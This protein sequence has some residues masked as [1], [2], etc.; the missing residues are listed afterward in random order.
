[1]HTCVHCT[2]YG[3]W[4]TVY[5]RHHKHECERNR[6]PNYMRNA[7]IDISINP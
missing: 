5:T 1:M 2:V 6:I 3:L 4:C 7:K